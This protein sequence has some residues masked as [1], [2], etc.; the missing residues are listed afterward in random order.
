MPLHIFERRYVR[1]VTDALGND[2]RLVTAH[3]RKGWEKDY[4]GAPPVFR[5]VTL[6]RILDEERLADGKYNILV[7]GIDRAVIVEEYPSKGFRRVIVRPLVDLLA[8]DGSETLG[9]ERREMLALADRLAE[10]YPH[11]ADTVVN[12]ESQYLHPGIMADV[13]AARLLTDAYERQSFLEERDVLRRVRLI[14]IHMRHRL[15]APSDAQS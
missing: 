4:Y 15:A 1:L 13:L 3:L 6:A 12:L 2:R 11:F 9:E 7:E 5:T 8:F 10:Q 14:S